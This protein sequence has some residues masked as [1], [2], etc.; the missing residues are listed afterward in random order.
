M[1]PAAA[2]CEVKKS[3]AVR[4]QLSIIHGRLSGLWLKRAGCREGIRCAAFGPGSC[5][6]RLVLPRLAGPLG[7]WARSLLL[8]RHPGLF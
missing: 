5:R 4:S 8:R 2:S 1:W 6:L 3:S 7:P